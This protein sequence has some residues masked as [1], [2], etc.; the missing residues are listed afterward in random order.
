MCSLLSSLLMLVIQ[1]DK[2]TRQ[3]MPQ[4]SK[5]DRCTIWCLAF[6]RPTTRNSTPLHLC[7]TGQFALV[8]IPV[9]VRIKSWHP[10]NLVGFSSNGTYN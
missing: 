8:F 4:Q 6:Q 2:S 1:G 7:M 9:S 3:H 5:C 10:F